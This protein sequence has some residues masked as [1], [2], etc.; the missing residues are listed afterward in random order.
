MMWQ[1]LLLVAGFTGVIAG[2]FLLVDGASSLARGLN[3]PGIV[4]GLTI[5][6]FGTSSPEFVVNLFA[7]LSENSE[8][9][10]GNVIGSNIL[11][12]LLIL[13]LS[14]LIFPLAVK[15]TTTW[16]EI[17]LCLLSALAAL[18][19]AGDL[20]IDG[21]TLALISRSDGMILLLFFTVFIAYNIQMAV[22]GNTDEP[23]PGRDLSAGKS[24]LMFMGGLILLIAGGK[25]TVSSATSLATMAGI[26]ERI[27]ALTIVSLGTSLP[28]LATSVVAAIRKHTDIAL[29]NIL[30][31]NIFNVFFI[32][33]TSAVISPV[34]VSGG[35]MND[36][37]F[38]A[39]ISLLIFIFVFTG[40]GRKLHRTEG[41]LFLLLYAG[42][43]VF[44]F[45]K[46]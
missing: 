23:V 33:G 15:T 8:M 35:A 45:I 36:L 31:S 14:T 5:V 32:L 4:I 27:I 30:G 46:P 22:K 28:E 3:V 17:P 11:N 25:V 2:A 24:I 1:V 26:S 44:I 29:G 18:V 12:I 13:G 39:F 20:K 43:L 16:F 10:L 41:G 19:L 6:A 40:K 7:S 42:Y 37:L 9:V 21:N 34:T 38:N